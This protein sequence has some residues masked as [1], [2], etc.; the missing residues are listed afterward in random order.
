M[1]WSSVAGLLALWRARQYIEPRATS[2][3]TAVSKSVATSQDGLR[4][5]LQREG[6]S[7]YRD[8]DYISADCEN[9]LVVSVIDPDLLSAWHTPAGLVPVDPAERPA[10]IGNILAGVR[11]MRC[12]RFVLGRV[13]RINN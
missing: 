10:L 13:S 5:E 3:F 4:V 2:T 12:G 1:V 8:A 9:L 11:A 6:L 7:Y